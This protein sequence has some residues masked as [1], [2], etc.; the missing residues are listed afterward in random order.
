[1]ERT[2]EFDKP[3]PKGD[4]GV[5]YLFRGPHIDWGVLVLSAGEMLGKHGHS[6]V[7]ET[8]YFPDSAPM[9]YI[10]DAPFRV[11]A[12]DAFRIEPTESHNIV[13]DTGQPIKIIFIKHIYRPQDKISY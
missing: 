9:I 12:G 8:F 5:K 13:N 2:N 1:M 6:E 3:F 7:E 10:N 4:S 11:K